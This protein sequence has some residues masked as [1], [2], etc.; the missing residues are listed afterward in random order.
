MTIHSQE[1]LREADWL[2]WM[3]ANTGYRIADKSNMFNIL[4]TLSV[5]EW[6][7]FEF[8]SASKI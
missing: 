2:E 1:F 8:K 6:I 4:V 5:T 3:V 7:P